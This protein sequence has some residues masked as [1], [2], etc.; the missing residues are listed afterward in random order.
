[1]R[2]RQLRDQ[3]RRNPRLIALITVII[4][5][6][7]SLYIYFAPEKGIYH[8]K[9]LQKKITELV[10]KSQHLVDKNQQLRKEIQKLENNDDYMEEI[11]RKKHG[12]LKKNEMIFEFTSAKK[13]K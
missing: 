2:H 13:K 10:D 1:M 6:L 3:K 7:L 4:S 12:L 11:A 9:K 8:Q 5:L